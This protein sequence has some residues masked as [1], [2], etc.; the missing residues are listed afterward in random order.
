MIA[1]VLAWVGLCFQFIPFLIR[2]GCDD[3]DVCSS[4]MLQQVSQGTI[5]RSIQQE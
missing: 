1:A 4:Q 3:L 2:K 5:T